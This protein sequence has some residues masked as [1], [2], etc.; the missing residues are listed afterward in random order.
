MDEYK[1]Y[2][3]SVMSSTYGPDLQVSHTCEAEEASFDGEFANTINNLGY[4]RDDGW[5]RRWWGL[6]V[7]PDTCIKSNP[8]PQ[9]RKNGIQ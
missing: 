1:H 4:V 7:E 6:F 2:V 8:R 3:D 9:I 5:I